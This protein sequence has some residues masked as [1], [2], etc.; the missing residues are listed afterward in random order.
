MEIYT[1]TNYEIFGR[2]A[3]N[4]GI[5]DRIVKKLMTSIEKHGL[6]NPITVNENCEILDG[7]H[8]LEACKNLGIPVKYMVTEDHY[9]HRVVQSINSAQHSWTLLDTIKS[10]AE[11]GNTTYQWLLLQYKYHSWLKFT[12]LSRIVG[13]RNIEPSED[14]YLNLEERATLERKLEYLD[15][16]EK[17]FKKM[18][19]HQQHNVMAISFLY[20]YEE[21]DNERLYKVVSK[22]VV[23]WVQC[24]TTDGVLRQIEE[25]YNSGLR[26][27]IP[28]VIGY[29][30]YSKPPGV[31]DTKHYAH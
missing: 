17:L 15:R 8:R 7:Q 3:G 12:T 27:K 10:Y 18:G 28:I 22:A 2:I 4:R 16:Y 9:D 21:I 19:G 23:D 26:R 11:T 13:V 29:K 5:N 1:T 14:F 30:N 20:D 6:V 25:F 31:K 24:A